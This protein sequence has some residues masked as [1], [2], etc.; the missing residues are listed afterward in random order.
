MVADTGYDSKRIRNQVELAGAKSEIPR[1]HNSVKAQGLCAE[2]FTSIGAWWKR[3]C[4]A[5]AL[6]GFGMEITPQVGQFCAA[7]NGK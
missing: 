1:A 3:F 6:P 7:F 2:V 4:P 5:A